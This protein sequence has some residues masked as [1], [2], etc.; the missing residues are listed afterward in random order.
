MKS[1]QKNVH[2]VTRRNALGA[3]V[4]VASFLTA[5]TGLGAPAA[6]SAATVATAVSVADAREASTPQASSAITQPATGIVMQPDYART[7]A[8]VAYVWGWPMVNMINRRARI[9]QA[10]KGG[11]GV[12]WL[13]S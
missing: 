11:P 3:G 10:P 13:A 7:I 12:C 1:D 9:T 4:G 8:Q 2:N 6:I 5:P